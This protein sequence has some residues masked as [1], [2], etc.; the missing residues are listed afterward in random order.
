[1]LSIETLRVDWY[2]YSDTPNSRPDYCPEDSAVGI[3]RCPRA[4][5]VPIQVL[6][7]GQPRRPSAEVRMDPSEVNRASN[8]T[9]R[10]VNRSHRPR[11][12]KA[13]RY[14]DRGLDV[15]AATD[16]LLAL[17]V[18]TL[19]DLSPLKSVGLHKLKGDRTGQSAMTVNARWRICFSF[20]KGAPVGRSALRLVT[21]GVFRGPDAEFGRTRA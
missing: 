19:Q 17:N 21:F 6:V 11:A 4:R 14:P 7:G 18:A 1:M 13:S 5:F 2:A 16:L 8:S 9:C 3:G 15:A 12:T 10:S 20:R